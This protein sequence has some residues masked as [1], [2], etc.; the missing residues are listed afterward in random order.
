MSDRK[1][2]TLSKRDALQLFDGL[3]VWKR[4][5]ER[6][7]HKPLLVLYALG[8]CLRGEDRMIP[9]ETVDTGLR[10]LLLEFAPSRKS[11]HPEYPFWRLQND[12]V[13]TVEAEQPLV[14]RKGHT[15]PKKSELL[16]YR[17]TGGFPIA[18]YD[19]MRQ[20]PDLARQTA[21]KV[22][23]RHFPNSIHADIVEAV[24]LPHSERCAPSSSFDAGFGHVVLQAYGYRCAVCGY[25]VSPSD[26]PVGLE[27][28]HIKWP[29]AGGPDK[30]VISAS[31]SIC[32]ALI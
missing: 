4:G 27:A 19:L 1:K 6:A 7:P 3:S 22:L 8:K 17:V 21:E 18:L 14:L 15:D 10:S 29:Q 9:F 5:G 32:L 16:K 2:T 28:A 11:C 26:K 12:K 30:R 23:L 25:E 13:W 31:T 20:D 24:G